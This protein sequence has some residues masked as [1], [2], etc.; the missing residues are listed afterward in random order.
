MVM[1][2]R[3][4]KATK[5]TPL[6]TTFAEPVKVDDVFLYPPKIKNVSFVVLPI[7]A[8]VSLNSQRAGGAFPRAV[9]VSESLIKTAVSSIAETVRKTLQT[10]AAKNFSGSLS[11]FIQNGLGCKYSHDTAKGAELLA[12][13]SL[14]EQFI[15]AVAVRDCD[16]TNAVTLTAVKL[17][18]E[19][20]MSRCK[21][22]EWNSFLS[23]KAAI[24]PINLASV[25][26]QP[27]LNKAADTLWSFL[28]DSE[29]HVILE[30]NVCV[31]L[32]TYST[33]S[34]RKVVLVLQLQ[35]KDIPPK[36][37]FLVERFSSTA[38]SV[39]AGKELVGRFEIPKGAAFFPAE[40][41]T[42]PVM[43][44]TSRW[45][46]TAVKLRHTHFVIVDQESPEDA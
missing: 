34:I 25:S 16:F 32:K 43:D 37:L 3:N 1:I 17:L 12:S 10:V 14:V 45:S 2:M 30:T 4:E 9:G 31:D 38:G 19:D 22:D 7:D 21:R 27:V 24:S 40:D 29:C 11:P 23:S 44:D 39:E 46:A 6:Y 28:E 20:A 41:S 42:T 36:T 13:I 33:T 8:K 35:Y 26:P 15:S 18:I 5:T